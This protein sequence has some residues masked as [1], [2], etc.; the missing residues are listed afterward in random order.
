MKKLLLISVFISVSFFVF[1]QKGIPQPGPTPISVSHVTYKYDDA[2]NR[3]SRTTTVIITK[4]DDT[5][6]KNSITEVTKNPF[7]EGSIIIAPN[8]TTGTLF[9]NFN[10]IELVEDTEMTVFDISGRK[11]LNQKVQ[12][13]REVLNL[14]N[15]PS[16]TYLLKIISGNH[17]IDYTVIKE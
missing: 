3:I 12:S 6:N 13:N 14:K 10:N 15:N 9:I 11:I 5:E 8:P 1:S 2:G 17:K 16:G 7:M 4:P